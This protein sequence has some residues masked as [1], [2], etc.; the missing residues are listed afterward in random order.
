MCDIDTYSYN[1]LMS[2]LYKSANYIA[3]ML[4][5]VNIESK[6]TQVV[7]AN[8]I[9]YEVTVYMPTHVVIEAFW[10]TPL[11]LQELVLLHPTIKW[12]V[13][14]HSE[15]P[16]L[17]GESIAMDWIFNYILIPNVYVSSNS[18]RA[19][20]SI[21]EIVN[22]KLNNPEY[23]KSH[24][25]LL[26]NYYPLTNNTNYHIAEPNVVNIGLFGAIRPLKN[27]LNQ[28]VAA[29]QFAN[30]I[31]KQLR[32]HINSSRIEMT[33]N[34][35]LKNL[36]DLFNNTQH[37]LVE[38]EWINDIDDYNTLIRSMDI[39]LQVAFSET[40]NIVAADFYN[41]F[42]PCVVSPEIFWVDS[43]VHANPV[44][45]ESIVEKLLYTYTSGKRTQI[46]EKSRNNILKYNK[47]SADKWIQFITETSV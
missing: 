33:N 43:K 39:G 32:F 24:T 31:E 29:I 2:G 25:P 4:T 16:F 46:I 42:I 40:F 9:D 28:A 11:K 27:H 45:V 12:I 35:I 15:I 44:S 14:N 37:D 20:R 1:G 5:D 17:S 10:V 47:T 38:Y 21:Y 18:I 22:T 8:S 19:S 6:I 13:R 23:V 34:A 3:N 26:M 36:R 7:D 41:N 30:R